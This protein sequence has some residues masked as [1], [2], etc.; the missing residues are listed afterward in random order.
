M[1]L[2]NNTAAE[3]AAYAAAERFHGADRRFYVRTFGCQQNEADSESLAGVARSLGYAKTESPHEADLILVN[4]CAVREHAELKALSV[5]G[6]Y[7]HDRERNDRLI[8]GVG[9]CMTAQASRRDQIK[10]SYPYVDFTF[11]AAGAAGLAAMIRDAIIRREAGEGRRDFRGDPVPEPIVEGVPVERSC[12]YKAWLTIMYGCDN[13]CSYCIVPHVRGRER[14]REPDAIVGEARSLV[15]SG[16]KDITL[17]GQ[18][19]NSYGTGTGVDI[20]ELMTRIARLEGDFRLRFMTSHPKDASDRLIEAIAENEKI[21]RHFHLPLQSGSD[22]I[23]A[24]MNRKYGIDRYLGVLERLRRAVPD[25]AVTSDIIVGFP[26]E[27]DEDFEDTLKALRSARYDMIYSFIFSPRAG[28]PAASMPDQVPDEV[29]NERFSRLLELQNR[30]SLEK[31]EEYVGSR[32][33]ILCE[34]QS[35]TD[36]AM[37]SGRTGG[38][39]IVHFTGDAP[40]GEFADVIITRADTFTLYGEPA[41]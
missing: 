39:K 21:A 40:E 1:P 6:Q 19:V 32:V 11:G 37:L 36:P 9:G 38:N 23:L 31:N 30:I 13:F 27:T 41:K 3:T 4:T 7:K 12:S 33:R 24:K 14:S 5:I 20:A 25:I 28:T 18:N 8:I 26:G 10:R 15:E 29:K 22:R 35:K 2:I 34:G 17:L 16:V